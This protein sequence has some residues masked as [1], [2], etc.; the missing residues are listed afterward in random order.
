MSPERRAC[1]HRRGG[2]VQPPPRALRIRPRRAA[3]VQGG[4]RAQ[5]VPRGAPADVERVRDGQRQA[6]PA[7]PAHHAGRRAVYDAQR[8]ARARCCGS[9]DAH[10]GACEFQRRVHGRGGERGARTGAGAEEG[11]D[12]VTRA[13]QCEDTLDVRPP[14]LLSAISGAVGSSARGW[15]QDLGG[16]TDEDLPRAKS[17]SRQMRAV[18]KRCLGAMIV[19]VS[20]I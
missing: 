6:A 5:V 11:E 3:N 12:G 1:T 4:P 18:T 13:V 14:D 17:S 19:L 8:C 10:T 16:M 7:A 9:V 15:H 2:G 20:L